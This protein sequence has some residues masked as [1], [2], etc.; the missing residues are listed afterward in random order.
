M[1]GNGLEDVAFPD[2]LLE[3]A[4]VGFVSGWTDVGDESRAGDVG[5]LV[6]V[7]GDGLLR[8]KRDVGG[9]EGRDGGGEDLAGSVVGFAECWSVC[10]GCWEMDVGDDFDGGESVIECD[11]GIEQHEKRLGDLKDV[12]HGSSSPRLEIADAV[13]SHVPNCS[14]GQW[15]EVQSWHDGLA[16]FRELLL[17]V[18]Q[19]ICFW[20]MTW[21]GFQEFSWI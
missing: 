5:G 11:D 17:E 8:G 4:D 10:E 19:R 15:R 2:V 7:L 1:G 6:A 20:T 18:G 13:I 21:T 16:A 9:L 3:G 12:F 14:S